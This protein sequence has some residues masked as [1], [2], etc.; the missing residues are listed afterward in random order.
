MEE[1]W[2]DVAGYEGLYQISNLGRIKSFHFRKGNRVTS[3]F[4]A[5]RGYKRVR[6]CKPCC[7]IK[8]QFIHRLVAEA[9]IPNL[10]NK[11]TVN[12]IDGNP[13]NNN[14]ENLEWATPQE[15]IT[16]AIKIGLTNQRGENGPKSKLTDKIVIEAREDYRFTNITMK[17]LAEKYNVSRST[18]MDAVRG[19]T[20]FIVDKICPP[21]K[22]S[23]MNF[24]KKVFIK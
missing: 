11:P 24:S 16:H 19:D 17:K 5:K 4:S 9:F 23:E 15:Q 20:W 3:G 2:K 10:D 7:K 18:I 21:V 6:L 1:T 14:S 8:N 12:H 13:S 22:I